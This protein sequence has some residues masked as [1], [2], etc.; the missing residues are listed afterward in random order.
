MGGEKAGD[1]VCLD[2]GARGLKARAQSSPCSRSPKGSAGLSCLAGPARSCLL[3]AAA[4]ETLR[5]AC[6]RRRAS[7]TCA[8]PACRCCC[9]PRRRA[10]AATPLS[11]ALSP[12]QSTSGAAPM[13]AACRHLCRARTR[14]HEMV[15]RQGVAHTLSNALERPCR[16]CA[17]R[18]CHLDGPLSNPKR[19]S[20]RTRQRRAAR[21]RRAALTVTRPCANTVR[22]A[23]PPWP[24]QL[25]RAVPSR[26]LAPE[27]SGR[28]GR[29]GTPFEP[30]S[31]FR[32]PTSDFYVLEN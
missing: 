1:I 15:R 4:C 13:V 11:A 16:N 2:R 26:S 10:V 23:M 24:C 20:A 21:A 30:T 18:H 31:D 6:R 9:R 28:E 29:R 27:G 3:L 7:P 19:Q 25:R 5:H 12:A 32:L 14:M 17:S 22:P 8:R